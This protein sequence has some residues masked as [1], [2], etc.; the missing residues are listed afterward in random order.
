M[1]Y[2]YH[3]VP[4]LNGTPNPNSTD[5]GK[6]LAESCIEA[7]AAASAGYGLRVYTDIVF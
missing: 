1:K 6:A 4:V 2:P 3:R 5:P 7:T